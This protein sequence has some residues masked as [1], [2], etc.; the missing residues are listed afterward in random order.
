VRP[1]AGL[2]FDKQGALYG[3]ALLGGSGTNGGTVFKL[4]APAKSQT[5]WKE[6]VLYSF[7]SLSSCADGTG[8]YAGLIADEQ[9]AL[10]STTSSGGASSAQPCCY[11]TV[12]KLTQ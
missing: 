4:T 3:T 7:C 9:G 2:I 11:G 5:G 6:T 8:P 12:F 1:Q 10:Y